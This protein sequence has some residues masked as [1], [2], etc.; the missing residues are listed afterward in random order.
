MTNYIPYIVAFAV[1]IA[2]LVVLIIRRNKSVDDN[3][4]L[5]EFLNSIKDASIDTIIDIIN[6]FNIED[7]GSN[8]GMAQE[9]LF[10]LLYDKIYD[11][12]LAELENFYKDN[13]ILYVILSKLLTKDKIEEYVLVLIN[14]DTLS[15]KI[16]D[17]LSI[18]NDKFVKEQEEKEIEYSKSIADDVVESRDKYEFTQE[19]YTDLPEDFVPISPGIENPEVQEINP[20]QDT[21]DIIYNTSDPTI[22]VIEDV[23]I[24]DDMANSEYDNDLSDE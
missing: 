17:L 3:K 5:E 6:K 15:E 10:K 1:F 18:A 24:L 8:F 16:T 4:R 14:E 13:K 23:N 11:L 21:D 2:V 9:E 22:E 7:F 19:D 20:P 12:S